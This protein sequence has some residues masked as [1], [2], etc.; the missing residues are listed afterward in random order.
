MDRLVDVAGISGE[1][2]GILVQL[3]N[4]YV[5]GD[6]DR[7]EFMR[8]FRQ[9]PRLPFER[10]NRTPDTVVIRQREGMFYIVGLKPDAVAINLKI[11]L[12]DNV[13]RVSTSELVPLTGRTLNLALRPYELMVFKLPTGAVVESASLASAQ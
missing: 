12:A 5:F 1:V 7:A 9:L 10:L 2:F 3:G 4:G 8:E 11:K 6:D 13:V